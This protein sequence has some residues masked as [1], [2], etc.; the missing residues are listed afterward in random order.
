MP[1]M[2]T[3]HDITGPTRPPAPGLPGLSGPRHILSVYP[4]AQ[5]LQLRHAGL[6]TYEIEAAP[7][8][9]YRT[10]TVYDTFSWNRNYH[11]EGFQLYQAPV[12]ASAVADNL[13]SRW[14]TGMVGTQE[15]LGPG[16]IL[17]ADAQPTEEELAAARQRQTDYFRM[18]IN[19]A[20]YFFTKGEM[21]SITGT[22][23]LAGEWM[24][25]KDREWLR[26]MVHVE[27]RRC[28]ACAEEIR[29]EAKICRFCHTD[30]RA[31]EAKELKAAQA[32]ALAPKENKNA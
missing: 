18:L 7:P 17:I 4:Q 24:G 13:I 14:T 6:T 2:A 29:G 21:K 8:G 23:R 1:N 32:A 16:I 28:P 11:A 31:F 26:P 10:L 19:E 27:L 20:D 30:L 15:G 12:P 9:D 5:S 25:V 3:A 22:H